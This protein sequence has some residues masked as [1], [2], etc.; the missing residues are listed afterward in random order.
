VLVNRDASQASDAIVEQARQCFGTDWE[1]LRV[2]FWEYWR[3]PAHKCTSLS[4]RS[5][6]DNKMLNIRLLAV[7][8]KLDEMRKEEHDAFLELFP[9][10][11]NNRNLTFE[12]EQSKLFF[13]AELDRSIGSALRSGSVPPSDLELEPQLLRFLINLRLPGPSSP[14]SLHQPDESQQTHTAVQTEDSQ[15]QEHFALQF[16]REFRGDAPL[17][18]LR[19]V[20]QIVNHYNGTG[21]RGLY[22]Y[23]GTILQSSGTGKTRMV[24]EL[25]KYAPLLFLCL[26]PKDGTVSDGFPP[27]DQPVVSYFSQDS[28]SYRTHW[29]PQIATV[30]A[31]AFYFSDELQVAA[32]LGAWFQELALRLQNRT[33]ANQRYE[34]LVDMNRY[35]SRNGNHSTGI[36]NLTMQLRKEFFNEV[37]KAAKMKVIGCASKLDTS[38]GHKATF[39][40]CLDKGILALGA[41]LRQVRDHLWS[42]DENQNMRQHIDDALPRHGKALRSEFD[43]P[44]IFV[45]I[46]ECIQLIQAKFKKS[47]QD[48]RL[49]SLRRAWNYIN[50]VQ[51]E[52]GTPP[53]WLVLLSTNSA[54]TLLIE[55]KEYI[56]SERALPQA[57]APTFVGLGFDVIRLEARAL[58]RAGQVGEA[59]HIRSYGRP[60]WVSLPDTS[61]WVDARMRL[62]GTKETYDNVEASQLVMLNYNILASRLALRF[63][64]V[65]NGSS[66]SRRLATGSVDRHMRIL[67]RVLDDSR[68]LVGA[69]SES[70]L[71]IAAALVMLPISETNVETCIRERYHKILSGFQDYCLP[72]LKGG[73]FKET[74][75]ELTAR[76]IWMAAWDAAKLPLM[77]QKAQHE[78]D[79]EQLAPTFHFPLR[80]MDLLSR[81]AKFD[82][83]SLVT[84]QQRIHSVCSLVEGSLRR[85]SEPLDGS[86]KVEAWTNFTHFD[87]LPTG[88]QCVSCDYLWYCWKRGVAL[89]LEHNQHGVDGI[90]PVFVGDLTQRFGGSDCLLDAESVAAWHMTFIAWEAKNRAGPISDDAI[91]AP[92]FCGPKLLPA[93]ASASAPD[94]E[95]KLTARGLLT[96]CMEL[97]TEASVRESKAWSKVYQRKTRGTKRKANDSA[98][99]DT[100]DGEVTTSKGPPVVRSSQSQSP[101]PQHDEADEGDFV[102]ATIRGLWNEDVYPCL[103]VLNVRQDLTAL[104]VKATT[105]PPH[106]VDNCIESPVHSRDR[107]PA[108]QRYIK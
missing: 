77:L 58:A 104:L 96:V 57:L 80:A 106:E 54:A 22:F 55:P 47:S 84:L 10:L 29:D 26:R 43:K 32:F 90:I 23:G 79:L 88:V 53:F 27:G 93:K 18:F 56:G 36:T 3:E 68:L 16:D 99:D 73:M 5:I 49:N 42:L 65:K 97:G 11:A 95:R 87:L 69:P 38:L 24:L 59:S 2:F 1:V 74:P 40:E 25:A 7:L 51:S 17:R 71:A 98:T 102:W 89:Q 12:S 31:P 34:Y 21:G 19:F 30:K 28:T 70:V 100:N 14:V 64:P 72:V 52:F 45:A 92:S 8:Q 50:S 76:I 94:I 81:L 46:D 48:D 6:L 101:T 91:L 41:E 82:K 66:A 75:F 13:K 15:T 37:C 63:V 9:N 20:L 105:E 33:D 86:L 85:K 4:D 35:S 78:Q 60:L 62:L 44:P 61:F 107:E 103:D 83:A 67:E 108:A 39:S